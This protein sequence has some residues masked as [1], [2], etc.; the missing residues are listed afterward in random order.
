MI[1]LLL[2]EFCLVTTLA[3]VESSLKVCACVNMFGFAYETDKE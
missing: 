2:P 1:F 3:T